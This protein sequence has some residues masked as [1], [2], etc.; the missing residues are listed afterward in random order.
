M[1]KRI[2]LRIQ[3]EKLREIMHNMIEV[4]QNLVHTE[5]VRVS[6]ELDVMLNE[7]NRMLCLNLKK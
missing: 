4:E 5:V 6:Q 3:I 1:S 2:K 7:Y